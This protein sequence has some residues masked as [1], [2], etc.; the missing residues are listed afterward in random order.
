MPSFTQEQSCTDG[1]TDACIFPPPVH[2]TLYKSVGPTCHN[3]SARWLIPNPNSSCSPPPKLELPRTPPSSSPPAINLCVHAPQ[4]LLRPPAHA[5]GCPRCSPARIPRAAAAST[6]ARVRPRRQFPVVRRRGAS[7][8]CCEGCA[9]TDCS[10]HSCSSSPFLWSGEE[11][12]KIPFYCY[13][14]ISILRVS[15]RGAYGSQR[16]HR[17]RGAAPG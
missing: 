3:S 8:A 1:S 5:T 16:V 9:R 11:L 12:P 6:R 17:V 10:L 14:L 2:L 15:L 13:C 4:P 7:P